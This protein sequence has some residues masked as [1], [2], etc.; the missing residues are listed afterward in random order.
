MNNCTDLEQNLVANYFIIKPFYLLEYYEDSL[1][2]TTE[3]MGYSFV[4][5]TNE[6]NLFDILTLGLL[7]TNLAVC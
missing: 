6:N 4:A 2:N 5:K 1:M 3:V 7:V